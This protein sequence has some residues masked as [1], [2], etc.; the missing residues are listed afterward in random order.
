MGAKLKFGV[1]KFKGMKIIGAPK[2]RVLR[3]MLYLKKIIVGNRF[4]LFSQTVSTLQ[5]YIQI[6]A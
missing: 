2:L 4:C 5:N 6:N 3:Y 1:Q